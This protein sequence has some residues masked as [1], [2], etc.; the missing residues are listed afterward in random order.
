MTRQ[1]FME[2]TELKM[3]L[4][5]V[6]GDLGQRKAARDLGRGEVTISRW[7]NGHTP[8]EKTEATLLRLVYLCHLHGQPWRKWLKEHRFAPIEELK[9]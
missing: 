4:V 8:I 9:L 2:P 7:L 1:S 6:W 5:D 3:I